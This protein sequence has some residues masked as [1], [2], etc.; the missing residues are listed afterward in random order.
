MNL[1][2]SAK[3]WARVYAITVLGTLTCI[4]FAFAFD[5]YSFSTGTW[6][7]G[8]SPVNNVVIPLLLAPPFFFV[9]LGKMR[10]LAIAHHELMSVAS[11]DGL[12]SLLNRR[13]FT[14]MIDGYLKRVEKAAEPSHDGLLLID[15]DHFKA[16]NDSYGHERGDEALVLI[17][18]TISATVRDT[19]LVGR[20]G[21]EEFGVFIPRQSPEGISVLAERIRSAISEAIFVPNGH[22]HPLSVSVGGVIFDE[23]VPYAD[24]Y[25]GADAKLYSAKHNGRNR[26]ELATLGHDMPQPA[27]H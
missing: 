20:I 25:R 2:W 1:D 12:T 6:R 7:W 11:T 24:L 9:L 19:D 16:V 21:G 17:A 10:E 22:R 4:A 5:S 13:A 26:V 15:V 3:G 27:L 23:T 14:E 8:T 18:D